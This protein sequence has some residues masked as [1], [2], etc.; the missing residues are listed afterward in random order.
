MGCKVSPY[1]AFR[2]FALRAF[3]LRTLAI[4]ASSS[5]VLGLA[6]DERGHL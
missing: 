4:R 2:T 1:F 3:A 5:I 6:L